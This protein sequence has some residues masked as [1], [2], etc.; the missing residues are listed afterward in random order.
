VAHWLGTALGRSI[1]VL[2]PRG[3]SKTGSL[4]S[5]RELHG[6]DAGSIV[7]SVLSELEMRRT[8]HL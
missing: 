6:I 3:F 5:V 7:R 4:E 1:P 2:G 8:G